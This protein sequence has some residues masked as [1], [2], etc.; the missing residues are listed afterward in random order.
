M[1]RKLLTR[2]SALTGLIGGGSG[3][4]LAG[5]ERIVQIPGM[6]AMLES[7]EKLSLQGQRLVLGSSTPLARE[8]TRAEISRNFKANG[9]TRPS[10]EDYT[11]LS[12]SGFADYRLKIDGLVMR[13]LDLSLDE[14]RNMPSR[15]QIT[16]HDC[17]EGWSAIG[18]WTGV[19]LSQLLQM[20]G[21]QPTARYIVFHCADNLDGQGLYYESAAPHP[22]LPDDRSP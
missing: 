7:A 11:R 17:V 16:R 4:L 10:D 19:P 15:S 6:L 8:Y 3:L 1:T 18:E 12:M 13:P 14:I 2:R 5:C 9:T 22:G 21:V 20:A